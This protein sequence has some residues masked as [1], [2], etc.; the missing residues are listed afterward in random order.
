MEKTLANA[1]ITNT[2]AEVKNINENLAVVMT[3]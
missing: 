3:I 1:K 2:A